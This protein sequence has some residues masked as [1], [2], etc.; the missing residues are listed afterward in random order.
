MKEF[1][2][3]FKILAV[4]VIVVLVIF[5]VNQV[6]AFYRNLAEINPWVGL[7]GA[8]LLA[9]IILGLLLVPVYLYFRLPP[10]LIFPDE[11]DELGLPPPAP[12]TAGRPPTG[13]KTKMEPTRRGRL[14]GDT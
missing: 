9:V 13:K 8:G 5:L 3:I 12:E 1:K 10:P 6:M 14:P 4:F 11:M 2:T 7:F